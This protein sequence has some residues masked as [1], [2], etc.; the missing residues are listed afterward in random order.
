M[1]RWLRV[2]GCLRGGVDG[3]G[4]GDPAWDLLWNL[5]CDLVWYLG[6]GW[7]LVRCRGRGL[8][9]GERSAAYLGV[10]VASGLSLGGGMGFGDLAFFAACSSFGDGGGLGAASGLDTLG[11]GS[12]GGVFGLA[13]GTA[14]GGVG[15]F[16]LMSAGSL[17]CV[18]C[19]GL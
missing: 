11:C 7:D 1:Q 5:A 13:Q 15:V 17:R 10:G 3:V 8:S 16:G 2:H 4:V 18:T 6:W 12:A 9:F 19:G 14:H